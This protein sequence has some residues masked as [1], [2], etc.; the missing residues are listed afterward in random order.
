MYICIYMCVTM[1]IYMYINIY[2]LTPYSRQLA[3]TA[4]S[5][6]GKNQR[7]EKNSE[8]LKAFALQMACYETK[9]RQEIIVS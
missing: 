1:Y 4:E 9:I 6:R 3:A 5:I 7:T 8:T 2:I